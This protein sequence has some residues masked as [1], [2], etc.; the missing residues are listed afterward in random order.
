MC[1]SIHGIY[2]YLDEYTYIKIHIYTYVYEYT[3]YDM[4]YIYDMITM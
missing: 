3:W 4:T 1:M 2:M